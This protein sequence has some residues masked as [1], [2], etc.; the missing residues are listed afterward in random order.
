VATLCYTCRRRPATPARTSVTGRKLCDRCADAL[1]GMAAGVIAGQNAGASPSAQVGQG[2]AT[3]GWF[4]R[5]R[6]ARRRR[7]R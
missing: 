2:I 1:L 7:S 4:A 5:I 3:T 6:E